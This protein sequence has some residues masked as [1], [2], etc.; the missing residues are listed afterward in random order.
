MFVSKVLKISRNE[1][2][3]GIDV[4]RAN[5]GGV[6]IFN[7]VS[8]NFRLLEYFLLTEN[9]VSASI[10]AAGGGAFVSVC[11]E[12]ALRGGLITVSSNNVLGSGAGCVL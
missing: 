3:G 7:S 11:S 2:I 4:N 6:A 5:G 10:Y 8:I 1:I 9:R 12:V